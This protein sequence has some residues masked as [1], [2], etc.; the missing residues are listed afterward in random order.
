MA[1][2]KAYAV[3]RGMIRP[4]LVEALGL[5]RHIQHADVV[6]VAA[7][8]TAAVELAVAASIYVSVRELRLASGTTGEAYQLA[9][10]LDQ[11]RILV[12]AGVGHPSDGRV[13]EVAPDGTTRVL[14]HLHHGQG[15][16]RY[17]R[18]FVA[19]TP[20]L[21][22]FRPDVVERVVHIPRSAWEAMTTEERRL[23]VGTIAQAAGVT[24]WS[25]TE[26]VDGGT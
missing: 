14:G 22:Q 12:T 24:E 21:M 3:D 9:G 23:L 2:L 11:A 17:T 16:G 18:R 25:T 19:V 10:L 15:G 13:I 20:V 26:P 4:G 7:S 8:K 1:K 5:P 6:V